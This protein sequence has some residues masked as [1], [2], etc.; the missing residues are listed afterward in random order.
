M[1]TT[2][3][4]Q[5]GRDF[6]D[7]TVGMHFVPT[8][9]DSGTTVLAQLPQIEPCTGAQLDAVR[10]STVSAAPVAGAQLTTTITR[11][12]HDGTDGWLN[13]DSTSRN[14]QDFVVERALATWKIPG[15]PSDS[16][17]SRVAWNFASPEW[18]KRMA[19]RLADT[20]FKE[21]TAAFDGTIGITSGDVSS[22]FRIYRGQVLE[23]GR[24]SL[25]G[26]T[27]TIQTDE[28]NW[29]HLLT[30]PHCD[31]VRRASRGEFSITGSSFQY[32]R[33]F[34]PIM[35]LLDEAR[36]EIRETSNA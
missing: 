6:A 20:A 28:I 24:K 15:A 17:A 4:I 10:W 30:A 26:A 19:A 8:T 31:Y 11:W 12:W 14:D 34:K 21:S 9:I 33:M 36:A 35:L 7:L 23:A 27:F 1:I 2:D 13:T 25:D 5:P 32:L 22:Q 18:A 3:Q 16:S 29:V